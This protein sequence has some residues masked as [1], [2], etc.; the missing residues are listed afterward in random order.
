[1]R[2]YLIVKESLLKVQG[3]LFVIVQHRILKTKWKFRNSFNF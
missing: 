3:D 1:M 2:N